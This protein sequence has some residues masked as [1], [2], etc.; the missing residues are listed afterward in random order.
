M[1]AI[2]YGPRAVPSTVLA[3]PVFA[4]PRKMSAV[5]FHLNELITSKTDETETELLWIM[6]AS[7][8]GFAVSKQFRVLISNT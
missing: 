6:G 8:L 1:H 4:V 5:A 7:L 3:G 2:S